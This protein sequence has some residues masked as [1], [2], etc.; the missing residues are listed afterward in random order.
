L[1]VKLLAQLS[2]DWTSQ[3]TTMSRKERKP[4]AK[5]RF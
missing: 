1:A 3:V 5:S 2:V 4:R